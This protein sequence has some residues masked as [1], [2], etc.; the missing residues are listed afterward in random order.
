MSDQLPKP[1]ESKNLNNEFAK[2][3]THAA[4]DRTLMAWIRTSLS[5]IGF[6]IGIFEVLEKT[7]GDTLFRSSKLVGLLLILLGIFAVVLAIKENKNDHVQLMN[8]DFR[9]NRK[10]SLAIRVGYA[11]M[12]IGIISFIHLMLK[13]EK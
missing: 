9:Y 10:S 13:L 3:R 1:D 4:Y 12:V 7:G 5:L 11:L 2:E 8:P 6:G